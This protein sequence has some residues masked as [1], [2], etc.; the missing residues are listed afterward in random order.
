MVGFVT[1]CGQ[2]VSPSSASEVPL[3]LKI[4]AFNAGASTEM[5][6]GELFVGVLGVEVTFVFV[7]AIELVFVEVGQGVAQG[8]ETSAY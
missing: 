4:A 8:V 7:V 5:F 3:M 1:N 2:L 6:V